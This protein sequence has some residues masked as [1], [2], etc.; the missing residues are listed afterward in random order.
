[1]KHRIEHL[2]LKHGF[3]GRIFVKQGGL[4]KVGV[5]VGGGVGQD[6]CKVPGRW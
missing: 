4:G 2:V 1:M 5:G 6:E 3:K